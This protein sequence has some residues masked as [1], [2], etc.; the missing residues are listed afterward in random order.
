MRSTYFLTVS[1]SSGGC[2]PLKGRPPWM[3]TP[4]MADPSK[5]DPHPLDAD[6]LDANPPGCRTSLKADPPHADLP[7]GRLPWGRPPDVDT[8]G[9]VTCG[10]PIPPL[11]RMTD[12][13]FWK[14]YLP[15]GGKNWPQ[16]VVCLHKKINVR[17]SLNK[18]NHRGGRN[19]LG[20]DVQV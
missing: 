8:P 15:A 19:K 6:P 16:I 7:K 18:Q 3:Q 17:I 9:H 11:K 4:P 2:R 13:R 10:K 14:H 5:A 12:R 20:P 1:H